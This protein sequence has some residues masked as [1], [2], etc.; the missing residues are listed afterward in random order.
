MGLAR[1]AIVIKG[2]LRFNGFTFLVTGGG[3]TQDP[4]MMMNTSVV[5][6]GGDDPQ[7]PDNQEYY[8]NVLS[9]VY[10][11]SAAGLWVQ[12]MAIR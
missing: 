7:S 3:S 8:G 10:A 9:N 6:P 4:G 1:S 5:T 12:K 2:G 11:K